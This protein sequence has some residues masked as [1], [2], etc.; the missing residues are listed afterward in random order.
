MTPS[1]KE[2]L[3]CYVDETGQDPTSSVF[4]VVVVVGAENQE[5]LRQT[6]MNIED[7]AETGRRKWHKSRSER[8][9]RYL[10]LVLESNFVRPD[11]FY[12]VYPKPIPYF[13]PMLEVLEGAIKIKGKLNT[14]ARVLVDGIDRQ[15]ASELTNALRVRGVSLEKVRSRRDESE[16]MIRL[17][18]MWAGCI[19]AARE[20]SQDEGKMLDAA[21]KLACLSSL[22]GLPQKR[23]TPKPGFSRLDYS[24][25]PGDQSL[26]SGQAFAGTTLLY[27]DGRMGPVNSEKQASKSRHGIEASSPNNEWRRRGAWQFQNRATA[28]KSLHAWETEFMSATFSHALSQKIWASL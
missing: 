8:R 15:K 3:Y 7:A 21:L 13:F 24:P 5:A 10:R 6:L 16:P 25:W 1:R 19:R 20:G 28:R 27:Y 4:V 18:D 22:L 14:T 12:G 2:K 11:V 9:L 23:K 17:A 26:P